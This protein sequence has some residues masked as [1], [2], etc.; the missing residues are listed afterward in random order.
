MP[1]EVAQSDSK[2]EREDQLLQVLTQQPMDEDE[3]DELD[4]LWAGQSRDPFLEDDCR[5]FV[6]QLPNYDE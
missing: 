3:D 4:A 1:A 6:L 2:T 5:P